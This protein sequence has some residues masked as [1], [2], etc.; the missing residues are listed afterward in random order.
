MQR[1]NVFW[2]LL[3]NMLFGTKTQESPK[4]CQ[5]MVVFSYLL[6]LKAFLLYLRANFKYFWKIFLTKDPSNWKYFFV[7][8]SPLSNFINAIRDVTCNEILITIVKLCDWKV[9]VCQGCNGPVKNNWLPFPPPYN[10]VAAKMCREYFKDGEKQMSGPSIYICDVECISIFSN[11][12][13]VVWWHP[14]W[15]VQ[16][17]WDAFESFPDVLKIHPQHCLPLFHLLLLISNVYSYE[18]IRFNPY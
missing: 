1:F 8:I 15:I 16:S 3:E 14:A 17:H 7:K 4:I 2:K 12:F 5:T 18:H 11:V 9:S 10:L 13:N 6:P